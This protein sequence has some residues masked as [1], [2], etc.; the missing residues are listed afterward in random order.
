MCDCIESHV[1]EAN[2][3][4]DGRHARITCL[5]VHASLLHLGLYV[6]TGCEETLEK[7]ATLLPLR[8][9]SKKSLGHTHAYLFWPLFR[10]RSRIRVGARHHPSM[11][12]CVSTGVKLLEK[13]CADLEHRA[14]PALDKLTVRVRHDCCAVLVCCC[15]SVVLCCAMPLLCCAVPVLCCAVLCCAV[16]CCA[17]SLLQ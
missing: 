10:L 8:C 2:K 14:H 13:E 17:C 11:P 1:W 3:Y 16:L 4:V 9:F 6:D 7:R 5:P 15:A 12:C